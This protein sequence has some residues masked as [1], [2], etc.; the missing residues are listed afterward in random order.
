MPTGTAASRTTRFQKPV[1]QKADEFSRSAALVEPT[2]KRLPPAAP[3]RAAQNSG[4]QLISGLLRGLLSFRI[5]RGFGQLGER[6]VSILL[7]RQGPVE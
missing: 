5:D 7:F 1:R 3:S 2:G 6:C 4:K